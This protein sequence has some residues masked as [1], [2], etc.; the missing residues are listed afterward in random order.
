MTVALGT[1]TARHQHIVD[2]LSR[3]IIRSQTELRQALAEQGI[4]VTQATLSRDLEGLGAVKVRDGAGDLVYAVP[5]EGGDRTPRPAHSERMLADSRLVRLAEELVVSAEGNGALV[6]IRTPPGAAH[7][8][9]SAVDHA[10]LAAV[11]GSIAGDDTVLLICR[12]GFSGV[13]L[14][15]YLRVVASRRS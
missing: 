4:A 14:A 1:K 7:F 15:E 11:M 2:I 5:S 10:N 6:V 12:E 8:L 13:E 3:R 9:A